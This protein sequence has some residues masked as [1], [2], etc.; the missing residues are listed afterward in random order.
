MDHHDVAL[1]VPEGDLVDSDIYETS[2]NQFVLTKLVK[3]INDIKV[4]LG[5][6][7]QDVALEVPEGDLV[8]LD[9]H[10][11]SLNQFVLKNHS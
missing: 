8:N 5:I 4:D 2:L 3:I 1:K 7:H 11:N 9:I 6:Y 10:E